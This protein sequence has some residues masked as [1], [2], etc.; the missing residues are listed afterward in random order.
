[1]QYCRLMN[2]DWSDHAGH[3]IPKEV[4]SVI[5]ANAEAALP[6]KR[7]SRRAGRGDG[8]NVKATKVAGNSV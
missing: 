4:R 1:M 6:N 2:D 7:V 3:S 5:A 8:N